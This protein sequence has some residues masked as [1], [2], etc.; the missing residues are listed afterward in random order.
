MEICERV[1]GSGRVW[2]RGRRRI[3]GDGVTEGGKKVR[4]GGREKVQGR[5]ENVKREKQH[6][7]E[8]IN[9]FLCNFG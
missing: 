2:V 5:D 3:S 8:S 4:E 9:G 6:A 7:I 1:C